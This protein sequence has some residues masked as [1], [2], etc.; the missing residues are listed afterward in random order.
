MLKTAEQNSLQDLMDDFLLDPS[1]DHTQTITSALSYLR[2]GKVLLEQKLFRE[3]LIDFNKAWP[4]LTKVQS[5]LIWLGECYEG[6]ADIYLDGSLEDIFSEAELKNENDHEY[7]Y[8]RKFDTAIDC[9]K[10]ALRHYNE[11]ER[12]SDEKNAYTMKIY[13]QLIKIYELQD[14]WEKALKYALKNLEISKRIH[15]DH[16][17]LLANSLQKVGECNFLNG[18]SNLALIYY[19]EAKK[20][21][22]QG[23]NQAEILNSQTVIQKLK[24][25][26]NAEFQSLQKQLSGQFAKLFDQVNS[27][28]EQ[29]EEVTT[30]VHFNKSPE[31]SPL[32][33]GTVFNRPR[34]ESPKNSDNKTKT[35][36][37]SPS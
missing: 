13:T 19:L 37:Q 2:Q 16:P 28:K 7:L 33:Q 12:S 26:M 20:Y 24:D 31:T 14:N 34:L 10:K 8:Q 32:A 22:V 30:V 9:Y 23:R 15:A 35:L 5:E 3:A 18:R 29:K 21:Y 25:R 4:L 36:S 27:T 17:R 11:K 1:I 6:I